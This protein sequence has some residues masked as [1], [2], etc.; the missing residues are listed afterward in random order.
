MKLTAKDKELILK[1]WDTTEKRHGLKTAL[2]KTFG[3]RREWIHKLLDA[4]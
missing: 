3:V 2:A 1:I 4:A